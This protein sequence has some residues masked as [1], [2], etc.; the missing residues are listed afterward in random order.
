MLLSA[1]NTCPGSRMF[2]ARSACFRMT[3]ITD[4]AC[5]AALAPW[6][7]TSIR[8]Q[9]EVVLVYRVIAEHVP[10]D[11]GPKARRASPCTHRPF[12]EPRR[13]Q[14]LDVGAGSRKIALEMLGRGH[15]PGAAHLVAQDLAPDRSVP[16][17]AILA[18]PDTRAP[19]TKV[20]LVEP[21]SVTSTSSA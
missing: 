4:A 1:R 19:S 3:F 8:L 21:R 10:A 6:P 2:T 5:S 18:V 9:R 12:G 16:P 14:R 7:A 17:L 11:A 13:Q 20:P 15:L